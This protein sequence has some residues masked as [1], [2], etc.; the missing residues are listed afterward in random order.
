MMRCEALQVSHPLGWKKTDNLGQERMPLRV[1]ADIGS[2][3]K[4]S[5]KGSNQ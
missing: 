2:I 5:V 1:N 4:V 3:G